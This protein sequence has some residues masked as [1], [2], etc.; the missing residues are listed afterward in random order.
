[1]INALR[2]YVGIEPRSY[3][4]SVPRIEENEGL[5]LLGDP[6]TGKSQVIHQL[7]DNIA[8]RKPQEAVVVYDPAGEFIEKHFDPD[9]DIVLNPLDARCPYWMPSYEG[10]WG[11]ETAPTRQFIAESFFPLPDNLAT[12]TQF[13]IK[14]ARSIFA[15]M[16][17]FNPHPERIV[18]MLSEDELIDYCVAGTEHAHL[19]DRDAKGQRGG[20]LATL[21]EIGETF[22]LL[23]PYEASPKRSLS[24]QR[25]A[26]KRQGWV[27]ITSTHST[28]E[29][30]RR[31]HAAWINI[32]LG[33]LLSSYSAV[34]QRPCWMII[35]E[36]H[37][38]KHLPILKSTLVEARKYGVK[39]VLGTQ[40]K[41]QFEEHYGRSAATML[42]SSHTKILF[43]CNEPESARWVSEMIGEEEKERPR[44]GTTATVQANGRDSI[45]YSTFTERRLVVSKEQIMALPNLH[46]Y[47]KYADSVVPFRIEA[48][49]RPTVTQPFIPRP[50]KPVIQKEVKERALALVAPASA[51]SNGK[52]KQET[53]ITK[54]MIDDIET[55]F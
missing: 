1:M 53:K 10:T 44:V 9:E 20:V 55:D 25:W 29:P 8:K 13:F 42:A 48:K 43:R 33:N 38:L 34:G 37:S 35:D 21:S 51:E 49:D 24:L 16:L 52:G 7:L 18:E 22:K 54:R 39:V 6:G 15:Q 12:N 3:T 31:L 5:L 19:I 23:P 50:Q 45:N 47:W 11:Y 46:G 14:A 36:V 2:K 32:L 17:M 41:A 30:L 40:N 4:L 27:F 26:R 28:R